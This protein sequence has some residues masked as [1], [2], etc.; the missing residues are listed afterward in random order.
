MTKLHHKNH[1]MNCDQKFKTTQSKSTFVRVT[2]EYIYGQMHMYI[3]VSPA[4][5]QTPTHWSLTYHSITAP[6]SMLLPSS[7][8]LPTLSYCAFIPTRE[9]SGFF[10]FDCVSLKLRKLGSIGTYVFIHK[11][12]NKLS[13]N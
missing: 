5:N 1:R 9:K 13:E 11:Q 4:E 2:T 3:H 12:Q 8:L 6:P 7:I 10:F